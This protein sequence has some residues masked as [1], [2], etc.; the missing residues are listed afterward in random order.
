M[1]RDSQIIRDQLM[2][3]YPNKIVEGLSTKDRSFYGTI[4]GY[5]RDK[6]PGVGLEEYIR[7]LGFDYVRRA[8]GNNAVGEFDFT[9][10][11]FLIDHFEDINQAVIAKFLG[12]S[13]QRVFQRLSEATQGGQD[14]R[15]SELTDEER[16]I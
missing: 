9:S 12:I 15:V 13:R 3:L 7:S 8:T 1:D 2:Y 4:Y 6:H 16:L 10:V 5:L 14:W 11:H